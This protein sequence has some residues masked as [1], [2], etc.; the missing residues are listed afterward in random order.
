MRLGF[1]IA[2]HLEPDLLLLDEI[3]AVGDAEFQQRCIR[4]IRQ[5]RE[6]KKT[7][8]FV[9]HS[10]PAV[11]SVCSRACLL[12]HGVV[13]YEG[14]VGKAFAAYAR[15]RRG[16]EAAPPVPGMLLPS[17]E[18]T[19]VAD[20]LD[21]DWLRREAGLKPTDRVLEL[22]CRDLER[23][24][25]L[26][27]FLQPGCYAGVD[28]DPSAIVRAREHVLPAEG[29]DP[30]RAQLVVTNEFVPGGLPPF[31]VVIARDALQRLSL[32]AIAR[33]LVSVMRV[34]GPD[35]RFYANYWEQPPDDFSPVRRPEGL[36][37]SLDAAPYHYSLDLLKGI[38]AV[39]GVEAERVSGSDDA[40]TAAVIV[41][42]PEPGR[43]RTD[44]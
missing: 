26:L 23:S 35:G 44:G 16:A 1:A 7:I 43:L 39:I 19:L 9:S 15:L 6:Q 31:D 25:P 40:G 21:L 30:D 24:V 33:S 10:E 27:R 5:L 29:I 32:N 34:V 3:F 4:T 42:R 13:R 17:V 20:A 2:V 18:R 14:S 8:V 12:D 22:G 38:A 41:F 36:T 37:T 11:K 28:A